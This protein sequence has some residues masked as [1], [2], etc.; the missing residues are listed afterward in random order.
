VPL[1]LVRG[2]DSGSDLWILTLDISIAMY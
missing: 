1:K 2:R